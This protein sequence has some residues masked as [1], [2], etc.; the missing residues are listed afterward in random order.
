MLGAHNTVFDLCKN[1]TKCVPCSLFYNNL[2]ITLI[3]QTCFIDNLEFL[4]RGELKDFSAFN[5][6]EAE[7][8]SEEV[9]IQFLVCN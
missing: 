1:M 4:E 3:H 6:V 9:S 5:G 8:D 7:E 2:L